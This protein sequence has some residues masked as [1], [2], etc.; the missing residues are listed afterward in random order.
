MAK[1]SFDKRLDQLE[2]LV[3]ARMCAPRQIVRVIGDEQAPEDSNSMLII[4]R[5]LVEPKAAS[6][7]SEDNTSQNQ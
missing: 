5:V 6:A 1:T 3:R 4:R 2:A 7:P